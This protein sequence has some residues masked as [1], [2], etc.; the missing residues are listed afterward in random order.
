MAEL[1]DE[2]AIYL[3]ERFDG[4]DWE[5]CSIEDNVTYQFNADSII[6]LMLAKVDKALLTN[7]EFYSKYFLEAKLEYM[8]RVFAKQGN[9]NDIGGHTEEAAVSAGCTDIA[10]AQLQAIKSLLEGK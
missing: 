10:K 4:E 1:R 3:C 8:E 6:S 5:E 7:W 9:R 2:I